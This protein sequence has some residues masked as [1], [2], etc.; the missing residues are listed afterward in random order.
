M[1][2]VEHLIFHFDG[3]EYTVFEILRADEVGAV[4]RMAEERDR[5]LRPLDSRSARKYFEDRDAMIATILRRCFRM[6]DAQISAMDQM[7]RRR[8]GVAF[9]LFLASANDLKSKDR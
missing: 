8:L 2:K 6:T 9:I 1:H 4:L 7:Q 3:K 5:R